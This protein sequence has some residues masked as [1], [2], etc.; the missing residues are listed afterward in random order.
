[1]GGAGQLSCELGEGSS[2]FRKARLPPGTFET[3]L[4]VIAL[5]SGRFLG[6]AQPGGNGTVDTLLEAGDGR[7]ICGSKRLGPP[8]RRVP[9]GDL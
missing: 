8:R 5:T 4:G 7:R 2:T 9:R 1:M 3:V 6:A